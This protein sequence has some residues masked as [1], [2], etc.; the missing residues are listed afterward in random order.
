MGSC[1]ETG[2]CMSRIGRDSVEYHICTLFYLEFSSDCVIYGGHNKNNTPLLH[3]MI[4]V[5]C[6]QQKLH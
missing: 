4:N 1:A 6:R 3:K 5:D 2:E